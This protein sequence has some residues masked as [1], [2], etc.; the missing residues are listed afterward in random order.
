MHLF[1]KE[2]K[3]KPLS[4]EELEYDKN[5]QRV[6][7]LPGMP[8]IARIN[9]KGKKG[10]GFVNNQPFTIKK[11]DYTD[12][13][14]IIE[15]K[16]IQIPIP[17]DQFQKMFYVAYCITVHKSQGETYNHAYTIHEFERFNDSLKY[18]ALSR[19]TDLKLINII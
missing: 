17:I 9:S 12:K 6:Y 10:L 13:N 8:I 15:D 7:L 18:V 19:A 5:S 11:I 1:V 16:D 14:I 2:K 4:L 3:A